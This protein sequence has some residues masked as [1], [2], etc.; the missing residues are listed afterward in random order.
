MKDVLIFWAD[1]ALLAALAYAA[2][3]MVRKRKYVKS[4]VVHS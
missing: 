1:I 3:K 4:T 2:Y